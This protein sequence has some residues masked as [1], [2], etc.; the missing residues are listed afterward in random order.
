MLLWNTQLRSP[1]TRLSEAT[2]RT[3]QNQKKNP[4]HKK[5]VAFQTHEGI[6]Q[7]RWLVDKQQ[8]VKVS[9][10][11]RDN[12]T[13]SGDKEK[14]PIRIWKKQREQNTHRP[15]LGQ[16]NTCFYPASWTDFAYIAL[17]W[18]LGR[19]GIYLTIGRCLHL[20]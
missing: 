19:G 12:I 2:R 7:V 9:V 15:S 8:V 4:T 18:K 6:R 3:K 20:S 16:G 17:V 13:P 11:M 10:R 5:T 14:V 1:F